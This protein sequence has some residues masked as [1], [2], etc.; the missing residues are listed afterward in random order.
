MVVTDV[1]V[2]T[3]GV[4]VPSR[5]VAAGGGT[6]GQ[7][8]DEILFFIALVEADFLRV[9]VERHFFVGSYGGFRGR[10]TWIFVGDVGFNWAWVRLIVFSHL[11]QETRT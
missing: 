2:E 6:G 4:D 10:E 8:G 3:D 1:V 11:G 9:G 7:C 5:F